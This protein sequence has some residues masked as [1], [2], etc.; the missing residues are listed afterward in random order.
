MLK[1][2]NLRR[3][4]PSPPIFSACAKKFQNWSAMRYVTNDTKSSSDRS[5]E[6]RILHTHD[7]LKRIGRKLGHNPL[8]ISQSCFCR[9]WKGSI[10]D[11]ICNQPFVVHYMNLCY[12]F[13]YRIIMQV[14]PIKGNSTP[15]NSRIGYSHLQIQLM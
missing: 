10:P 13:Y 6:I 15:C 3:A 1:Q 12:I 4:S 11:N 5:S 14:F 2:Q 7:L 9:T 8:Y